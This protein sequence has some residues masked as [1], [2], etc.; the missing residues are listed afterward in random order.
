MLL[1]SYFIESCPPWYFKVLCIVTGCKLHSLVGLLSQ[2][3]SQVSVRN[4]TFLQAQITMGS[5]L[6]VRVLEL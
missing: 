4:S 1:N 2:R 3:N 6:L 5:C